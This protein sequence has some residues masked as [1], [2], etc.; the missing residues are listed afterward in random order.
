[1]IQVL[2]SSGLVGSPSC[3]FMLNCDLLFSSVQ[4]GLTIRENNVAFF[5][6][7]KSN[8]LKLLMWSSRMLGELDIH[9]AF[10]RLSEQ[11]CR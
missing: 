7:K 4:H 3:W 8:F 10:Y 11:T 2:P 9:F 6:E 5:S 1:M